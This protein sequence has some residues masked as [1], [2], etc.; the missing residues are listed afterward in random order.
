VSPFA[1][2]RRIYEREDCAHTF[3]EDLLWYLEHGYVW[4]SPGCFAMAR[5]VWLSPI[6]SEAAQRV[7]RERIVGRHVG[8]SW[9]N[10]WHCHV[11]AGSIREGLSKLP[12]EL[13]YISFERENVFRY[14][15][16]VKF[17]KR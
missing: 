14:H 16:S 5:P 12:F 13:P 1:Q 11:V 4:N 15:E 8:G 7:N 10:C 2:A 6:A 9:P 3:A 17:M